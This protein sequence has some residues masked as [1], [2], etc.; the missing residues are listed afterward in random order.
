MVKRGMKPRTSA[1]PNT[2]TRPPWATI[3][4]PWQIRA[5]RLAPNMAT[6]RV[7]SELRSEAMARRS[8]T[9]AGMFCTRVITAS[10]ISGTR[11]QITYFSG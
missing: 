11:P 4:T 10:A 6:S 1:K 9:T 5:S 7:A 3:A 2:R 8:T